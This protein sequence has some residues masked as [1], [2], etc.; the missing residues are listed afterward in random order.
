MI[1]IILM[2]MNQVPANSTKSCQILTNQNFFQVLSYFFYEKFLRFHGC[3]ED[4]ELQSGK[5]INKKNI[6]WNKT[7]HGKSHF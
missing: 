3:F 4:A 5:V 2:Q 7:S 6:K 1:H